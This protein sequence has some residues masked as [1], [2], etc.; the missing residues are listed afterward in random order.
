MT[1]S[2]ARKYR[3][4]IEVGS[5]SLPDETALEVSELFPD[6][7]PAAH[8]KEDQRVRYDGALY[9]CLQAHTAQETWTPVAA[10][11]LWTKV[12]IP[13][14]NVIPEWVQPDSTNCYKLGDKVRH[15]GKIWVSTY[16]GPNCWEPGVYG[17]DEVP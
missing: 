10:P 12:L 14:E 9:R 11:S 4:A 13:D 17:W 16:D 2:N 1:R 15:N 3:R 6:W 7:D 5:Q 8:Y